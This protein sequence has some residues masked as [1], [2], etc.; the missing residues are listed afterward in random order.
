MGY[1]W[2]NR[3]AKIE[4]IH[5]VDLSLET[6]TPHHFTKHTNYL[7]SSLTEIEQHITMIKQPEEGKD[8][9]LDNIEYKKSKLED[10]NF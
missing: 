9:L 7:T 10:Q 1:K 8:I 6:A 4:G 2:I 5:Y 3:N